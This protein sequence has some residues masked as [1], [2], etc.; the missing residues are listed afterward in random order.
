MRWSGCCRVFLLLF[1]IFDI[2]QAQETR[3]LHLNSLKARTVSGQQLDL[4][5]ESHA[6]L[7]GVSQY[8]YWPRLDS[9]P[10][11]L[12]Q[13]EQAL[14]EQDFNVVRLNNPKGR[15]LSNG[16]ED[17]IDQFGYEPDNRLLIFFAGHGHSIG[18]KGFLLP[19]DAP[20]PRASGFRRSAFSMT[21][22]MSWA[23][24]MEAK[25]ALFLFDS[26][27]SG[28]VFKSRNLPSVGERYIRQATAQPVRQFITAGGADQEVPAVSTFTPLLVRAIRGE[29]DLNNDGYVTGSELGVHL[30]QLVPRYVDQTPQYGKIRDPGLDLGDFV[31]FKSRSESIVSVV[32]A[33]TDCCR[34]DRLILY[35]TRPQKKQAMVNLSL[36][37]SLRRLHPPGL[38]R[39]KPN[40]QMLAYES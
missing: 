26:C 34:L 36:I 16:I 10:S 27:F 12:D 33:G 37:V 29:G 17:F 32:S 31:F 24:D 2:A 40:R 5:R 23:R 14:R 21:R 38:L 6:L 25:H 28:A 30:S 15:E 9:I 22:V 11:E 7:I 35:L 19:V 39:L 13:V 8:T 20:L 18:S 1:L 4:Y 3:G